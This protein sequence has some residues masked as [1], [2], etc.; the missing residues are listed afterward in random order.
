METLFNQL[1]VKN[2]VPKI[3][4]MSSVLLLMRLIG[5]MTK[6]VPVENTVERVR[7]AVKG[8]GNDQEIFLPESEELP[9]H[10]TVRR[11]HKLCKYCTY[12]MNICELFL[13]ITFPLCFYWP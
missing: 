7:L 10:R 9:V 4:R 11:N 13:K 8:V 5:E 3:L 2:A 12:N 1:S 6:R